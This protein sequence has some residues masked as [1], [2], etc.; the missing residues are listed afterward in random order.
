MKFEAV[1]L[2]A[3]DFSDKTFSIGPSDDYTGIQSSIKELGVINPPSLRRNADKYQIIC[4]WKRIKACKQLGYDEISFSVYEMDELSDED[5]LKFVFYEN[6]R[7]LND[8]D[9][10]EVIFKFKYICGLSDNDLIQKVLPMIGIRPMRRNLE[11][12]MTLA[13]VEGEIKD[14]YYKEKISIDQVVSLS[15]LEG[16]QRLDVLRRI[17]LR[18]KYNNNETRETIRDLMTIM[19]RDN[20]S[21]GNIIDLISDEIGSSGGKNEFRHVLRRLRYPTLSKVEEKY[22]ACLSGL[23]LPKEISIHHSPFF[24]GNDLEIRLRFRASDR[25][26]ELLSHL[27]SVVDDTDIEKLL[28]TV[29]EGE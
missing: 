3:L 28:N 11:R 13:G 8:I 7:R 6:Q 4:G 23:H 26:S 14:A 10:A 17:L 5:C 16:N 19:S 15:E 1:Q 12:Y 2:T 21:I 24:E 27:S 29:R 18:F 9:K 22:K 25:L 20:V